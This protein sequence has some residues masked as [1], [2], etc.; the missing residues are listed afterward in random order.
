[1]ALSGAALGAEE[2]PIL[3]GHCHCGEVAFEIRSEIIETTSCDC[4]GCQRRSGARESDYVKVPQAGFHLTQG[5]PKVFTAKEGKFCDEHGAWAFC[6]T[7]GS[8]V[9]WKPHRGDFLD[10]FAGAIDED[11]PPSK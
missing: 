5:E 8:P 2:A 7:C 6:G 9:Y 11:T 10:V 3:H 4:E 1:M